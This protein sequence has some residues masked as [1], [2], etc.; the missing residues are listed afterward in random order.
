MAGGPGGEDG[1]LVDTV[2]VSNRGPLAF[3]FDEGELV[4]GQVGGG[5]AGSLTPMFLGTGAT[6]VAC[7]MESADRQAAAEGLMK[8]DGIRIELVEPD[9][10]VYNLAYNVVSNS[11]LWFCHH[12][13]FD[14]PRRPR[15]DRHW[16]E[17][18]EAYRDL[19][20]QFAARVAKVAPE[21]ARVL[22][23][24]Y[25]LALVG[26]ELGNLR[27]DLRAV[28]F[29]HTPFADP[30]VL[31]MLP[32]EMT[33]EI[34][35]GMSGFGSCG[36][37]TRRWA[38]A[39]RAARAEILGSAGTGPDGADRRSGSGVFVS[40]LAPDSERLL[41]E[42]SSNAVVEARRRLDEV[43][44]DRRVIARVDRMELSKNLLR[45]FLAFEELLASEPGLRGSVVFLAMAYPSRQGLA[46]YL[47]YQNEVESMVARVNER[48]GTRDW[49]PVVRDVEDDYTRSLAVLTRYDVLLV[50]PIRDGLNLVAKEG[51]LVNEH[52]GA[53]L[54]SREAGAFEELAG[55][56][57]ELNPFDVTATAAGL[58]RALAMEREE[59]AS[60]AAALRDLVLARRPEDWLADQLRA[61]E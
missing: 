36:F 20:Q 35:D 9:P 14:A 1:S 45:G 52:D 54:L 59:R 25:H 7:A 46:E 4:A 42:A 47:G 22:V 56:A 49:T 21:N 53:L 60:R 15:N 26:A 23:Q 58:A 8:L 2:V 16:V 57:I 30:S 37:H 34:L 12:H 44:G 19:N 39:Y 11:A 41:E 18:W 43:V 32:D 61:A 27:P 31:R 13:L 5:L 24:D 29:T 3:R 6:W 10:D 55:P 38:E 17:A 50:N 51:P 28:H 48:W 40:P 33:A